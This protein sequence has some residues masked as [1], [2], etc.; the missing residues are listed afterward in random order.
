MWGNKSEDGFADPCNYIAGSPSSHNIADQGFNASSF[1]S[2]SLNADNN[3]DDGP[4]FV[5]PTNFVGVPKNAAQLA[6]MQAADWSIEA[7]SFLIDTFYNMMELHDAIHISMISDGHTW[8][9]VA[10]CLFYKI[11]YLR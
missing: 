8:H 2:L 11:L 6:E 10:Y 4:H 5:A 9:A 1:Q 7:G 3:A